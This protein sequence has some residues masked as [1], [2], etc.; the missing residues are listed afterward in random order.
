MWR[1]L[2]PGFLIRFLL[3]IFLPLAFWFI[4]LSAPEIWSLWLISCIAVYFFP[5]IEAVIRQSPDALSIAMLNLFLGWTLVGWVVALAWSVR[6]VK[7]EDKVNHLGSF[8]YTRERGPWGTFQEP[9]PT[10]A[11]IA[12]GGHRPTSSEPPLDK[13]D[14]LV[15]TDTRKCPFCAEDVKVEAI[16]CK[17]CKS[18]ISQ[19]KA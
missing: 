15:S 8:A 4:G 2:M 13:G 10:T 11:K 5:S 16:L 9:Q 19:A 6:S 18:D 12:P 3:A 14:P 1:G 7:T 17:H